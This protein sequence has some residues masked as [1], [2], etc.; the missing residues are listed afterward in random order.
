M[1]FEL[2]WYEDIGTNGLKSSCGLRFR[3]RRD[4]SMLELGYDVGF[5]GEEGNMAVI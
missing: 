4:R 2:N 5:A 1:T 3:T